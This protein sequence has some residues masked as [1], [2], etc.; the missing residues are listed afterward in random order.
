MAKRRPSNHDEILLVPFLDI[1]CSLIGVLILI[2]VVLTVSSVQ[3]TNGRT[4]EELERAQNYKEL[5]KQ[6]KSEKELKALAD[7]KAAIVEKLKQE[8][9]EKQQKLAKL[10]KLLS[11]SADIQKMNKEMS[12]NLLKELDN[13][14]L[15]IEGFKKQQA[16][17][18]KEIAALQKQITERQGPLNKAPPPVIVQPGGSGLAKDTKLYFVEAS[19]GKIVIYWDAE[20]KTLVS[21]TAAVVVADTSYAHFL[22]KVKVAPNAKI[23]FLIREDGSA[24]FNN[25]AGWAI[26]TYGFQQNQIARLPIPGRGEIDLKLFKDYL[27]TLP[28]PADAKLIPAPAPP[29]T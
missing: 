9:E 12:Q 20:K 8:L 14:L 6:Q 10:R 11:S 19:A 21:S 5:L 1:L 4:P 26:T 16:E 27:G 15:E 3:Q 17:L 2:I 29:K 18:Q 24:S 13:L 7:A 28:P 23:I 25:A 22:S